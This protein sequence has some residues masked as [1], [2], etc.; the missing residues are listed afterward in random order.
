MRNW[1]SSC[2]LSSLLTIFHFSF[3]GENLSPA[4]FIIVQQFAQRVLD[5]SKYRKKLHKYLVKKM[6]DVAPNMA[7]LVGVIVGA[8]LISH[9]G[10]LTNLAM[11][12]SS[13]IQFLG[14]KT[15]RYFLLAERERE[16]EIYI[17]YLRRM[18]LFSF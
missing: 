13:T 12:R 11:C 10:G 18:V 2:S 16:R 17:F 1:V 15:S 6:N 9:A 4:N 5:L 14:V 8:H 7:S 3:S